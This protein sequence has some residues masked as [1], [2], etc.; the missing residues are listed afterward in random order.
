ML[1][2]PKLEDMCE[3]DHTLSL[4][5]TLKEINRVWGLYSELKKNPLSITSPNRVFEGIISSLIEDCKTYKRIVYNNLRMHVD[6]VK[7]KDRIYCSSCRTEIA[8][9][10]IIIIDELLYEKRGKYLPLRPIN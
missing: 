9:P 6:L 2:N 8:F 5:E 10:D 1:T 4:R 3:C 7:V